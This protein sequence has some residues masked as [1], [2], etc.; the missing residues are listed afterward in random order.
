MGK[1]RQSACFGCF[2]REGVTPE[3][4]IT[5]A[6]E[7]GYE[8]VEMSPEERWDLIREHGMKVAITI[9]HASLPE[10]LNDPDNHDRIEDELLASIERAAAND[11][12]GT[13]RQYKGP[14][15]YPSYR[16]CAPSAA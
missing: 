1:I 10:G 16:S 4:V 5:R 6:A 8:S 12:P 3:Q 14:L 13:D 2:C 9:G 15:G 7:I 11:I